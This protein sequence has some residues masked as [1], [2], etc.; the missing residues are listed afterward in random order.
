[1]FVGDALTV[2]YAGLNKPWYLVP[3]WFFIMVGILYYLMSGV[4]LYRQL[5]SFKESKFRK[6][7]LGL[8]LVMLAGNEMW[9]YLFFGLESIFLGFISLIPFSIVVGLLAFVLRKVDRLSYRILLPYLFWLGYDLLWA[10]G[11]YMRNM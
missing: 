6:I 10:Y 1:M 11:L 5:R 4:I 9:N 2:W 7:A 8:I 3:L